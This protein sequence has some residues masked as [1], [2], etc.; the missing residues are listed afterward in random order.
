[1]NLRSESKKTEE[2]LGVTGTGNFGTEIREKGEKI[3]VW[4]FFFVKFRIN[5]RIFFQFLEQRYNK[6]IEKKKKSLSLVLRSS[7]VSI[8]K[9]EN[10]KKE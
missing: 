6:K 10:R 2:F 7:F 9:S 8:S 5:F 1:M 4:F 3:F